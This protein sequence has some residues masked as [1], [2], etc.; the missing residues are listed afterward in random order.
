MTVLSMNYQRLGV[1]WVAM[2]GPGISPEVSGFLTSLTNS[3]ELFWVVVVSIACP[4]CSGKALLSSVC[5]GLACSS[6]VAGKWLI[7][8]QPHG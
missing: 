3:T 1:P 7:T 8:V 2:L 5:M 6:P 4:V